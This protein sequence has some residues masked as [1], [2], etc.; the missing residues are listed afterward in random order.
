[1][2]LGLNPTITILKSGSLML[3]RS[4]LFSHIC[5]D[6]DLGRCLNLSGV[7]LLQIMAAGDPFMIPSLQWSNRVYKPEDSR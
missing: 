3:R 5:L 4:G 2:R 7:Q 1:M 6:I